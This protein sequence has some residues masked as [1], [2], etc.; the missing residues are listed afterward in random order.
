MMDLVIFTNLNRSSVFG[1]AQ[2][3][4]FVKKNAAFDVEINTLSLN[5]VLLCCFTVIG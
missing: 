5:M 1:T 3:L 2:E 4:Q